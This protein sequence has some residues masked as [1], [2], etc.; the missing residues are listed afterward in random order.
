MSGGNAIDFD[1][2]IDELKRSRG[3]C[4]W[5][6]PLVTDDKLHVND[7]KAE[8]AALIRKTVAQM[9]HIPS[10]I[11]Y[12]RKSLNG[13]ATLGP[14]EGRV[15]PAVEN[16][17][18]NNAAEAEDPNIVLQAVT[19]FPNLAWEA[20]KAGLLKEE[21]TNRQLNAHIKEA[22]KHQKDIDLLLDFNLEMSGHKEDATELSQRA[23]ELLDE[24]KARGIDLWKG[25][26]A[27][28]KEKA[29]TAKDNSG[30]QVDK[31]RSK[32]QS[33]VLTGIQPKI[34]NIGS[35]METLKDILRNSTR[36][37]N[38]ITANMGKK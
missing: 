22:E 15:R 10:L 20:I 26:R 24:L 3:G 6:A 1:F 23:N 38:T 32:L 25:E 34:S 37:M 2:D 27:Y 30:N 28:S 16:A 11:N 17:V 19:E 8:E 14:V 29:S 21:I 35:I 7:M 18:M 12:N 31:A 36:L 13:I 5:N 4:A 9:P 33:I